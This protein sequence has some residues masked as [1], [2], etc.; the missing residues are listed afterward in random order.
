MD[1][2]DAGDEGAVVDSLRLK[3][4]EMRVCKNYPFERKDVYMGR[5]FAAY[6]LLFIRRSLKSGPKSTREKRE[7]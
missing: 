1:L 4:I 6:Q 5:C 7:K 2:C 3:W